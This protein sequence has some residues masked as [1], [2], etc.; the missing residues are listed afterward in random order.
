MNKAARVPPSRTDSLASRA[1][2]Y[3]PGATSQSQKPQLWITAHF[4]LPSTEGWCGRGGALC[5]AGR[6]LEYLSLLREL[7]KPET[8]L[9]A[10][11]G[12]LDVLERITGYMTPEDHQVFSQLRDQVRGQMQVMLAARQGK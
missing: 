12:M 1:W 11:L 3:A 2:V 8:P 10:K 5:Y 6:T 7:S 4:K 9:H